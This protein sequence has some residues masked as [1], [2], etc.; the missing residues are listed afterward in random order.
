MHELN[1]LLGI[2]IAAST[3]YH[4]QTDGQTEW[5]NQE[6]EQYLHLFIN[7]HQDDC[8]EWVSLA[9]FAYNK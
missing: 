9:E 4:P 5:V 6:I 7:Q 1:K 3:T 2:K 8:F